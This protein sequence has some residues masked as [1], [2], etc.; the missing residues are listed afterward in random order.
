MCA[1]DIGTR[2]LKGEC[3]KSG[4]F[5]KICNIDSDEETIIACVLYG[6]AKLDSSSVDIDD[7]NQGLK[8]LLRYT[9]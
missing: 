4:E 8:E 7:K 3:M 2:L 9:L 1:E 6:F 5:Y